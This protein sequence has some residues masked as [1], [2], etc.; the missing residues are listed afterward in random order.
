MKI[1]CALL[2][3]GLA[4]AT[5]LG[6]C[7]DSSS[8][9]LGQEITANDSADDA[10]K[11][12]EDKDQD[13]AKDDASQNDESGSADTDND[14]EGSSE[15]SSKED[16]SKEDTDVTDSADVTTQALRAY[17]EILSAAP[18][19][20]GEHAE[21]DDAAFGYEDNLAMFG[22]HLDW[23]Y[24][25]DINK[26]GVPELIASSVINFRW[27]PVYVYTY[28][29]GQAVLLQDP[30]QPISYGT[31]DQCAIANGAYMTFFCDNNHVHSLWAGAV[32]G[33][34]MEEDNAYTLEGT[35]LVPATCDI[36]G[37]DSCTHFSENA[38]R[39]TAENIS[40]MAQ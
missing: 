23:F 34:Q 2:V 15:D 40:Y 6:G 1:K 18:A 13:E 14:S 12:K 35:S 30:I 29:D 4:L 19:I 32:M 20:E 9:S 11:E 22:K 21:L 33:D 17:Y 36:E 16:G 28:A 3:C 5:V 39:N 27:A 24:V 8:T 38:D 25:Y 31:F 26:D 7:G 37:H 10:S